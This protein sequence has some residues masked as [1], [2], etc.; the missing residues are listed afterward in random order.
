M[1]FFEREAQTRA[2]SKR[3]VVMFALSVVLI[4]LAI[5]GVVLVGL[6]MSGQGVQ[7][8]LSLRELIH[9]FSGALLGASCTTVGIIAVASFYKI[10]QLRSGGAAVAEGLGATPLP[11]NSQDAAY[12][13]LRNVIE[14]VAIASGTPVPAIY[15]L[16]SEPGINAFAAGFTP[17]DAA[18]T[19][20]RGCLDKLSRDELQGVIAHEFSHIVNGDMRLSIRLMGV[21]FGILV[22]AVI[23]REVLVRAPRARSSGK[24]GGGIAAILVAAALILVIGYIGVFFG[25]LIKASFSRQRESL[26]DASAVQFTRQTMG[27]VGALKKIAGLD[28]GSKFQNTQSEEVSH[29]LFGDGEGY[30]ALF[31]THPPLLERIQVL[32]P[33]F[34]LEQIQRDSV[35]WNDPGYVP[36]DHGAPVAGFAPAGHVATPGQVAARVAAPGAEQYRFGTAA[37]AGLPQALKDVARDPARA[38]DLVLALMLDPGAEVRGRQMR[39]IDKRFPGARAGVE[40]LQAQVAELDPALRLPLAAIAFPGLRQRPRDELLGMVNAVSELARADGRVSMFEYCLGRMVR[41]HIADTLNP[42]R[43]RVSGKLRIS[44]CE[45]EAVLLLCAVAQEGNESP[46]MARRAFIAGQAAVLPRSSAT[47]QPAADPTI[48]LDA[49]LQKLDGLCGPAKELL[50][51]ALVATVNQDGRVTIGEAELVRAICAA[52]HCPLPPLLEA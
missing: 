51:E 38:R 23:A 26:A 43:A 31:A 12:R 22:I 47:Y 6:V 46:E 35:K 30:S 3:L 7:Q 16:E 44:D 11:A 40:A 37:R 29:M 18:V 48:P 27:L 39:V 19:V 2:H 13:R 24:G 25:R 36:E 21:I 8:G 34:R 14:E 28:A 1:N 52:L 42:A 17:A 32:E 49:A 33:S 9:Q 10:A 50:L 5:D 4:V 20:T 41:T 45:R 15:V